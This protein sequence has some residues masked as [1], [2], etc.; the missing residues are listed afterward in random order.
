MVK[1]V[2]ES[3]KILKKLLNVLRKSETQCFQIFLTFSHNS[4]NFFLTFHNFRPFQDL[5]KGISCTSRA[6]PQGF[7][8]KNETNYLAAKIKIWNN[9]SSNSVFQQRYILKHSYNQL[10]FHGDELRNSCDCVTRG[11][12]C[13]RVYL[14]RFTRQK[15]YFECYAKHFQNGWGRTTVTTV[16]YHSQVAYFNTEDVMLKKA[17]WF[18]L[19]HVFS[20]ICI[21]SKSFKNLASS[22]HSSFGPFYCFLIY[23]TAWL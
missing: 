11:F 5:Q 1:I 15:L 23:T 12:V 8:W 22:G 16:K 14:E 17:F 9:G 7:V 19:S 3:V 13:V 18:V 6:L 2:Q 4:N 21:F 20:F 10:K